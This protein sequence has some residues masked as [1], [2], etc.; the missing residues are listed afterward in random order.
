MRGD[1][2]A[3]FDKIVVDD[4]GGDT[5]GVGG[6]SGDESIFKTATAPGVK[7]GV[8]IVTAVRLPESGDEAS[9][10]HDSDPAQAVITHRAVK[11][12]ATEKREQLSNFRVSAIDR[13]AELWPAGRDTRWKLSGN[14]E[15]DDW[16]AVDEYFEEKF[17][18]VQPVRDSI[19]TDYDRGS[20]ERRMDDY[21]DP[22]IPWD[23]LVGEHPVFGASQAGKDIQSVRRKLLQRNQET[24][25]RGHDPKRL[26]RCL[27]RPLDARW[28]YWE[29]DYKL[30][31]RP[32][33][34]LIPYWDVP[35]QVCLVS[36]GTRRSGSA[37]PL[38]STAVPLF[39]AMDPDARALPLWASTLGA[40]EGELALEDASADRDGRRSNISDRWI[41]AARGVGVPGNDARVAETVF[42]AICG[43]AASVAWLETQPVEYDDF[44]TVPIPA[45]AAA[46]AAAAELGREYALLVDPCVEVEGVSR[47]TVRENLR[48]VAE[49]DQPSDGD[50]VLGYGWTKRLGG[51]FVEGALLWG[52]DEGWRNVGTDVWEFRLGGFNPIGKHLSYLLGKR[53]EY[54]DRRRV[55][56]MVRRIVA[57]QELTQAAD[58]HFAATQAGPLEPA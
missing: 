6:G 55:T 51:K 29:P 52:P 54:A 47:G 45:N 14:A 25:S 42:Y 2:L 27:W 28:L 13:G 37:R 44:P 15:A 21:F 11:G 35:G 23:V 38:V 24:G 5:R 41:R 4:L 9:G 16:A 30:L 53:L 58:V 19:V 31:N 10:S 3:G 7:V 12:T 34:D 56:D 33:P 17:S 39:H 36:T 18:G 49:A 22:D 50:P 46:L 1:L 8:A 48:G 40:R 32:C 20:I 26:V 57:I 43:V